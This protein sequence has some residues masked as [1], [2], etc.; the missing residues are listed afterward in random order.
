M[1]VK[2]SMAV[3]HDLFLPGRGIPCVQGE[4]LPGWVPATPPLLRLGCCPRPGHTGRRC[5]SAATQLGWHHTFYSS[6]ESVVGWQM[7][8]SLRQDV[9][10]F[11]FVYMRVT[12]RG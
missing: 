12:G 6:V 8:C 10:V 2:G 1:L 4:P 7:L 3:A 5:H 9:C 11:V